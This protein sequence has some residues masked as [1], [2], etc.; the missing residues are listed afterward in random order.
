MKMTTK[1]HPLSEAPPHLLRTPPHLAREIKAQREE[2]S[3]VIN[4][5]EVVVV[6]AGSLDVLVEVV[7]V[8]HTSLCNTTMGAMNRHSFPTRLN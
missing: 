1:R 5:E 3:L 6:Q 8:L 2:E 4:P 7:V